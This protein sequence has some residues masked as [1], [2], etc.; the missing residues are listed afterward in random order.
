LGQEKEG[1]GKTFRFPLPAA[2]FPLAKEERSK[3]VSGCIRKEG[4][5]RN[6]KGQICSVKK[7]D[8]RAN[9]LNRII[10]RLQNILKGVQHRR[11]AVAA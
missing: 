9:A 7:F 6:K 3:L 2:I 1:L 4:V 5:V 8:A 11:Q 10:S